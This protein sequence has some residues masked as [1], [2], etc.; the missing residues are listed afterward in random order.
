LLFISSTLFRSTLEK[1][2]SW[3]TVHH[4]RK[5]NGDVI[6][7]DNKQTQVTKHMCVLLRL[8]GCVIQNVFLFAM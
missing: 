5:V 4:N 3:G 8:F 6:N 2:Y 7:W 1:I